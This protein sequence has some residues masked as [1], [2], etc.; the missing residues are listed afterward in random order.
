MDSESDTND[1]KRNSYSKVLIILIISFLLVTLSILSI[2][3]NKKSNY[4]RIEKEM[5]LKAQTYVTNNNFSENNLYFDVT[6]L[7]ITLNN[8]CKLTSGVLYQ[9]GIYKPNLVCDGYK[10]ILGNNIS[11][12]ISLNGDEVIVLSN[13]MDYYEY[14]YKANEPV[15]VYGTVSRNIGIYDLVYVTR[16]TKKSVVRKVVVTDSSYIKKLFPTIVF[17]SDKDIYL[18]END[19]IDNYKVR[20][21]DTIDGD[22]TSLIKED[23]NVDI[24]KQGNY[25]IAYLVTNSR[26]YTCSLIRKVFVISKNSNLNVL[27]RLSPQTLTNDKV[28]IEVV[29][30]KDL[31][32]YAIL[33][34][35][36]KVNDNTFSYEV[37]ENGTY[38]FIIYD[39]YG[40]MIEKRIV[41]SNIDKT[42]P[43]GVCTVTT[44]SNKTDISVN[45]TT[46]KV[47]R[48]YE[49]YFD[50]NLVNTSSEAS[51]QSNIIKPS[52]V[53][54]KIIDVINN[55]KIIDC[56][57]VD[58]STPEI[59]V[60][61]KGKRCLEGYTCFVQREWDNENYRYCSKD[62]QTSCGTIAQ[63]GCSLVS[64][65]TAISK[66]NLK[67][68]NGS[69]YTPYT[70][71][72]EVYPIHVN[73]QCDGGCSGW[74]SVRKA[75]LA[76]GLSTPTKF[77]SLTKENLN[78][79]K[80]HLR[81]GYPIIIQS[82]P[83]G[84]Y[85]TGRHLLA[86]LGIRDDDYVYLYNTN[87][88]SGTDSLISGYKQNDWVPISELMSE[89]G[90]VNEFM[91]IGPAGM[92]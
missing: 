88:G 81:K 10:S 21:I 51:Y 83:G 31:F 74:S 65:T 61:N 69:L 79:F 1:K 80:T 36:E 55:S 72:K 71:Y 70:V 13:E 14:G 67:S 87:P 54:V 41:V 29:A 92:Y 17:E 28:I 12:Y 60:D 50:N 63:H 16:N 43:E 27:T 39:K 73:G 68:R 3:S 78:L 58:K 40:R 37:K 18:K 57:T 91:P 66:F 35:N 86:V 32:S 75:A 4:E 7:G 76:L 77:S 25:Q 53:K 46:N 19:S 5:V 38:I 6:M 45:I 33:P 20:A 24:S 56:N 42:P 34:N 82:G 26:G 44:Y 15:D 11:D 48:N 84:A 64:F 23:S 59:Y 30:D 8:N 22:I 9:N 62:D 47:I 90:K 52:S 49:Y 85:T 89:K 2:K